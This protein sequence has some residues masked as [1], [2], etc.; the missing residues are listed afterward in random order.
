V[1]ELVAVRRNAATAAH[2]K[3]KYE[4]RAAPTHSMG[5]R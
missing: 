3:L 2:K 1:A 4:S 5:E